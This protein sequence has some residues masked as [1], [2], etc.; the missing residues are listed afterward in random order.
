MPGGAAIAE[1]EVGKREPRRRLRVVRAGGASRRW[2]PS[3]PRPGFRRARLAGTTELVQHID[4]WSSVPGGARDLGRDQAP[5]APTRTRR[6]QIITASVQS[7]VRRRPS[8]REAGALRYATSSQRRE[9][10]T[11]TATRARGTELTIGGA[12]AMITISDTAAARSGTARAENIN[13]TLERVGIN[14]F[15]SYDWTRPHRDAAPVE[16][17]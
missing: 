12:E 3:G 2:P 7:R 13:A 11:R 16:R 10:T 1:S 6:E 14:G 9:D 15:Q 5:Q 8:A 4:G 17:L